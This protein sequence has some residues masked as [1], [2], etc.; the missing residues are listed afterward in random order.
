[1]KHIFSICFVSIALLFS[2][3]LSYASD[4]EA[5]YKKY[6]KACHGKDP[7]KKSAMSKPIKGTPKEKV[8]MAIEGKSEGLNKKYSIMVKTIKKKNLS[9][10]DKNALA[11][12]L[13]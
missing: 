9:D 8:F 4:G 7:S 11:E 3:Q 5:L 10:E 12:Y 1:M 6:C 13:Q 2:V